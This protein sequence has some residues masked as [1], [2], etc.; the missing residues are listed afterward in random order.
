[1]IGLALCD[2]R[3]LWQIIAARRTDLYHGSSS[4]S[5]WSALQLERSEK[6]QK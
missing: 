6:L 3:V 4:T 2:L 5:P 1:M